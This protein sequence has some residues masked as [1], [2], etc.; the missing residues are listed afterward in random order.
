MG[1]G[2]RQR[3]KLKPRVVYLVKVTEKTG[4]GVYTATLPLLV[5]FTYCPWHPWGS[6]VALVF[7]LAYWQATVGLLDFRAVFSTWPTVSGLST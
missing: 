3:R 1:Q 2:L 4:R 7:W 5:S 6:A